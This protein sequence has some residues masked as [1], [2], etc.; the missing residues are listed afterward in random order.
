MNRPQIHHLTGATCKGAQHFLSPVHLQDLDA[1]SP[2]PRLRACKRCM[3][4]ALAPAPTPAPTPVYK[5][6]W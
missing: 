6:R 4:K 3:A 1:N 5:A 2:C